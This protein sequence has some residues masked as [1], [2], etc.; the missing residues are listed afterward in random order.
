MTGGR[1]WPEHLDPVVEEFRA[2]FDAMER[3]E[4]LFS[5]AKRHPSA[6]PRSRKPPFSSIAQMTCAL[7]WQP[8]T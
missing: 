6:P 5:Y 8:W 1:K 7:D 2:C 4:L 3:Y